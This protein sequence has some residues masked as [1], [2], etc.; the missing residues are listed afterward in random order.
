MSSNLGKVDTRHHLALLSGATCQVTHP[1]D[2]THCPCLLLL[3]LLLPPPLPQR[4]PDNIPQPTVRDTATISE[5]AQDTRRSG[6]RRPPSA[7]GESRPSAPATCRTAPIQAHQDTTARRD[8]RA[9]PTPLH[10]HTATSSQISSRVV[11]LRRR[12]DAN[13]LLVAAPSAATAFWVDIRCCAQKPQHGRVTPP[14]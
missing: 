12:A 4:D 8:A 5:L 1:C 2:G 13:L 9:A 7:L 10:P 6:T 11:P 14:R 3:L